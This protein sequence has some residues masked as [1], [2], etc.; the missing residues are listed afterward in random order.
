M[1]NNYI[2]IHTGTRPAH[3][4]PFD[5]TLEGSFK[6]AL[7]QACRPGVMTKVVV[8]RRFPTLPASIRVVGEPA[9]EADDLPPD[10]GVCHGSN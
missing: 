4:F 5:D 3:F 9:F 2:K 8:W 10:Y 1:V 6:L 7:F